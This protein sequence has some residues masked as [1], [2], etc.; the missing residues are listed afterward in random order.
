MSEEDKSL[1]LTGIGKLGSSIPDASWNKLVQTACD[2]FDALISPITATTT[3][4]GRLIRAKFDGMLDVQKV[5]AADATLRA[6]EKVGAAG[7]K[8][9]GN[10]KSVILLR[11]IENASNETDTNL[12]DIWANL[13]A[14]EVLDNQVHPEFPRLLERL[15]SN[16]AATLAE[17]AVESRKDSVKKAT[18]SVVYGLSIMGVSISRLI[19]EESDFSREHLKNSNLITK[20]TGQWQLTLFG[21]EF[22]KVV[23]DPAFEVTNTE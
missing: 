3:G 21:E 15:S 5:L 4:L 1:D 7:R 2:T 9:K 11:S 6:K 13:M 20:K 16:D 8:P 14:N 22:L 12:R 10:P 23:A 19:E 17:L 18:R